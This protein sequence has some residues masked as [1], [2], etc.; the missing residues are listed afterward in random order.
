MNRLPALI[1]LLVILVKPL[2]A[3]DIPVINSETRILPDET[4]SM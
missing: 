2:I 3:A 1:L 4:K